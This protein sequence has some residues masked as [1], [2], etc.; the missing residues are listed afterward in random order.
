VTCD[1]E[2]RAASAE[3]HSKKSQELLNCYSKP[4]S[5]IGANPRD[6]LYVQNLDCHRKDTIVVEYESQTHKKIDLVLSYINGR[7][8]RSMPKDQLALDRDPKLEAEY[9]KWFQDEKL[10]KRMEEEAVYFKKICED[11]KMLET[12]RKASS[13]A[14]KQGQ[15]LKSPAGSNPTGAQ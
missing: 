5:W 7:Y 4:L 6:R 12:F 9:Q 15:L 2:A 8:M 13:E 1:L 3:F 14:R 10:Q 11:P